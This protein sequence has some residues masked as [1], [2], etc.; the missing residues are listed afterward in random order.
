MIPTY[1]IKYYDM[2]LNV[3]IG[4]TCLLK[5]PKCIRQMPD[6]EM[7]QNI[8]VDD[9]KKV[10]NTFNKVNFCGTQSD[11]IY[12]PQ[13]LDIMIYCIDNNNEVKVHT[14]GH[15][16]SLD[17]WVN[18]A[19][20]IKTSKDLWKIRLVFS[21]DGLPE[22]A[23]KHKV[24][25]NGIEVWEIMK[26][27]ALQGISIQWQYIVFKY[28]EDHIEQAHQMANEYN[29]K[30]ITIDSSI[31]DEDDPL[32]PTKA[33][34]NS[35]KKRYNDIEVYNGGYH[36][37]SD[38]IPTVDKLYPK[39][40][41]KNDK[42]DYIGKPCTYDANGYLLPCP[43]ADKKF[44][45]ALEKFHISNVEDPIIDIFQSEEW[46][47]FYRVLQEEPNN[48]PDLCK[49]LC[50]YDWTF[51]TKEMFQGDKKVEDITIL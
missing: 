14:C 9:W 31:W 49:L 15:G 50:S 19:D 30:F 32:R 45:L 36:T 16:K 3:D 18:L 39:C 40:M 6:F 20:I 12:H 37:N 48:A 1:D 5:C 13:F 7:A 47:E 29:I 25:Q 51:K 46:I 4:K 43:W 22:E 23:H 28:N 17:W 8:T 10:A 41:K 33:I 42:G 2:M 27:L 26:W 38:I 35:L 34:D 11:P 24:G 44:P 21:L